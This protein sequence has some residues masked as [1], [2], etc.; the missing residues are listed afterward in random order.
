MNGFYVA[1]SRVFFSLAIAMSGLL[2]STS[3]AQASDADCDKVPDQYGVY[4]CAIA[5]C[6]IPYNTCKKTIGS[7]GTCFCSCRTGPSVDCTL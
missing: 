3:I 5:T 4:S 7:S 1:G 6:S 2:V